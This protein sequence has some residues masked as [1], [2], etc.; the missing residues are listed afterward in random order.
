MLDTL[1]TEHRILH[2]IA[3]HWAEHK[4]PATMPGIEST[5]TWRDLGF[6]QID[7]QCIHIACEDEFGVL[8]PEAVEE[9]DGVAGLVAMVEREM[10][11][12]GA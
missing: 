1:T 6:G 3:K 5:T 12:V 2:L 8:L 4:K 10:G 7:Q 11:R 9:V